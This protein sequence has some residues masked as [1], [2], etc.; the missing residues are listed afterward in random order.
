M[1]PV[2]TSRLCVLANVHVG[3]FC[4]HS[5]NIGATRL[6]SSFIVASIRLYDS[7]RPRLEELGSPSVDVKDPHHVGVCTKGSRRLSDLI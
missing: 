4:S 2:A 6:E 7:L 1:S 5:G 3:Q